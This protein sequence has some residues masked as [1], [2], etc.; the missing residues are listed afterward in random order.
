MKDFVYLSHMNSM[1][2]T[3]LS[4]HSISMKNTFIKC[5]MTGLFLEIFFTGLHAIP[6]KDYRLPG[7]SSILMFPIYGS[8]A[9]LR[10]VCTLIQKQSLLFRGSVYT[11]LIFL[12][13]YTSGKFLRRHHACPWDYS[14][15]PTNI[16]GLIRLDFAPCWFLT[17]L[18][19]EQIIRKS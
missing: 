13:E 12:A 1:L 18:L 4:G 11:V 8:A 9:L 7:H 17:G 2:K 6:R 10:P 5:G 16:D 14:G 15:K 3:F 19:F